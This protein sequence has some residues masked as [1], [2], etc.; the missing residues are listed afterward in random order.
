[1]KTILTLL[2]LT[3]GSGAVAQRSSYRK[4][5]INDGDELRI[6]VDIDQPGRSVHYKHS[7][8][9]ADM[10]ADAVKLLE[11][12]IL[13]SLGVNDTQTAQKVGRYDRHLS[14][15]VSSE[16]NPTVTNH[17]PVDLMALGE[18]MPSSVLHREDK[19]N[20]RLWMQYVFEHNGEEVVFE[21]TANIAGKSEREKKQ[22]IQ[23]TE[24]SLGLKP[25]NQ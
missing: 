6:R 23:E 8:N 1:M 10:D 24:R 21:R 13:D 14:L 5:V 11:N 12:H 4:E 25:A 19:E 3:I 15:S 2:L 22:I 9:V 20:A 7:F 17:D 16:H 18:T